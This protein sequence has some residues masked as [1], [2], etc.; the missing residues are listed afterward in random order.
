MPA[1]R[2]SP[3]RRHDR[4]RALGYRWK[5]VRRCLGVAFLVLLGW[6]LVDHA[7]DIDWMAVLQ[8]LRN[9]QAST[10]LAAAALAAVSHT[11]FAS[12]DLIGRRII[13]HTLSRAR[14]MGVGFVSYA[15]NLNFG[16]LIGAVALRFKLYTRLGLKPAVVT[17]VLGLS[18]ITNWIGYAALAGALFALQ[19]LALP[20]EWK[21]GSEGLRLLGGLMF[22]IALGYQWACLKSRRRRWT[23]R[24]QVLTLPTWR[25]GLRQLLVSSLNWLSI[26]AMVWV[27]LRGQ[28]DFSSVLSVAL[29]AAVAGVISHVPAG[30]GVLEAVYL[31]LL[32]HRVGEDQLL[33]ALLAYRGLYYLLPLA[34]ALPGY[35]IVGRR[36]NQ[37]RAPG[38]QTP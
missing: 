12:Y 24:G 32:S 14:V 15:F 10:L 16:S 33:A 36:R 4:P 21:I 19:P 1:E 9:Y 22:A 37:S 28:V 7:R 35:W 27:L 26:A 11:L 25:I 31:A 23:L 18:V 17:Q 38:L 3:R 5:V 13:G 2:S 29:I 6:L 8:A 20:P 34:L 30:L